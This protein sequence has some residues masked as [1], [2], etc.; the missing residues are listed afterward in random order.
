MSCQQFVRHL[1]PRPASA[2]P[3]TQGEVLLCGAIRSFFE[4]QLDAERG[5]FNLPDRVS[6]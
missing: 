4:P 2:D 6:P 1:G 5:S 3:E